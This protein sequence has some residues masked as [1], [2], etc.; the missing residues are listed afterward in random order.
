MWAK[1]V[2]THIISMLGHNFLFQDVDVIWYR[3]PLEFFKSRNPYLSTHDIYFQS[4][5]SMQI[6]YSPYSANSGFYYVKSNDKTRYLFTS[7]IYAGDLLWTFN[8]HQQ[9]LGQL[10][11]EH[12]SLFNLRVKILPKDDFPG[13]KQ[14]HSTDRYMENFILYQDDEIA[15]PWMFHMS[16]TL[17]MDNKLKFMKQM[18]MWYLNND[19]CENVNDGNRQNCCSATPV[20]SCHYKDKPSIIPCHDSPSLDKGKSSFWSKQSLKNISPS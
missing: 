4:D 1:V 9:V 15:K 11:A 13:G 10:L 20:I 19:A 7:L 12:H 17:N 3:H 8:S 18:G 6:R 14:Y 16:W 5:G 2:C